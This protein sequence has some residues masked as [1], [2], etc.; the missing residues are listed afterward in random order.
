MQL[1]GDVDGFIPQHR[2]RQDGFELP[3]SVVEVGACFALRAA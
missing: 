3:P 2:I 1:A